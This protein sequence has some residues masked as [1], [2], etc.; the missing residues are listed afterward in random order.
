V[1][2][3]LV[4]SLKAVTRRRRPRRPKWRWRRSRPVLGRS[5]TR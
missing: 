5:A 4:P 3:P 1:E 2:G